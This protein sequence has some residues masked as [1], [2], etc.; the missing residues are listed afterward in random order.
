[1]RK[2]LIGLLAFGL[3]CVGVSLDRRRRKKDP[4]VPDLNTWEGEGGSVPVSEDRTAAQ[5]KTG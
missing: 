4:P 3:I 1:M 5:T 2:S